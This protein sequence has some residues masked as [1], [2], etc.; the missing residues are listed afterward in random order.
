MATNT[1]EKATQIPH[2]EFADRV[3]KLPVIQTA[4]CYSTDTYNKIKGSNTN[5]NWAL[6]SVEQTVT[7]ALEQAA[8]I[9]IP[10]MSSLEKPINMADRTLCSGLSAVES[11][12][13]LVTEAPCKVYGDTKAK[14]QQCIEPTLQ[15]VS[16]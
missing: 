9:A 8:P 12:V 6:S 2:M 5:I 14:V 7:K 15:K 13:P 3:W 11:R 4:W 16:V 1:T 10:V